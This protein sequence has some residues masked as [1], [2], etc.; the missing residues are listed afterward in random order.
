MKNRK[1]TYLDN[2]LSVTLM[3]TVHDYIR[4][5]D[6]TLSVTLMHTVH[7]YIRYL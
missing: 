2:T 7:D 5:C 4:T 1:L 3:L 6:N